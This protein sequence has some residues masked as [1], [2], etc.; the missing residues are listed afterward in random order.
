MQ[1]DLWGNPS[2]KSGCIHIYHDE[3]EPNK[4]W[5]LIGLLFVVKEKIP[6]IKDALK[7]YRDRERYFSEIHF[8]KLPKSFGGEGGKKARLARDWLQAYQDNL[9]EHAFFSA[10]AIDRHSPAYEP[11][12][13]THDFHAY[14]RFTAMAVKSGVAWH[15]I[16][17]KYDKIEVTFISD[18]K[19]RSSSLDEGIV[20]NF[21]SYIP[22]KAALD[23]WI[24]R[25]AEGKPY[26]QLNIS[27]LHPVDSKLE[28]L[29]QLT[30][31][32]LGALQKALIGGSTTGVKARLAE[33]GH[34]WYLDIKRKPWEQNYK[35][36]RKFNVWGF[37]NAQGLPFNN[38]SLA[39][40]IDNGPTL[41]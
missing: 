34:R 8:S 29:L 24:A 10:L 1:L 25:E 32:I 11:R 4:R 2:V 38:L 23:N 5:L 22:Y 35:M 39:L 41:F 26:P 15:M 13:F 19:N 28:D 9:H 12:R 18:A 3:S 31:L 30:D 20:D 16:P 40:K 7:Y 14:N 21:E 33:K 17:L 37:P 6:R 36:H 27:E